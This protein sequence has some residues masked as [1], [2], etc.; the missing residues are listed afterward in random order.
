MKK[1]FLCI[2]I[3]VLFSQAYAEWPP[4]GCIIGIDD[5]SG[6]ILCENTIINPPESYNCQISGEDGSELDCSQGTLTCTLL[7]EITNDWVGSQRTGFRCP[8]NVMHSTIHRRLSKN[9]AL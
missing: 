6:N 3:F 9:P 4:S 8:E 5:E 2:A 1:I 7:Q